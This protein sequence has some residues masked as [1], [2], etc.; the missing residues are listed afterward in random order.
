MTCEVGEQSRLTDSRQL[1]GRAPPSPMEAWHVDA[2]R[3][4]ELEFVQL[5]MHDPALRC[6]DGKPQRVRYPE[7]MT[8]A[9]AGDKLSV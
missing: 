4:S 3:E 7:P 5:H 9:P 2:S 6:L 1:L 8:D